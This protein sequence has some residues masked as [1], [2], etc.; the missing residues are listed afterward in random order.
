MPERYV[1][2]LARRFEYE[3]AIIAGEIFL[4]RWPRP[5]CKEFKGACRRCRF[6][7]WRDSLPNN[8][9]KAIEQDRLI[10]PCFLWPDVALPSRV[11]RIGNGIPGVW[12]LRDDDEQAQRQ[13]GEL[14]LIALGH[15][16]IE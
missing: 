3:N 10:A 4:V 2:P 1:D 15:F 11:F 12:R 7:A 8:L 16:E 5:L 6:G 9:R 13:L 14:S